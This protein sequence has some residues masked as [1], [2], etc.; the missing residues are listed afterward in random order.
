[1]SLQRREHRRVSGRRQ[2][3]ILDAPD[4]LSPM[5]GPVGEGLQPRMADQVEAADALAA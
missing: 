3:S 2:L 4:H 5:D 1:M